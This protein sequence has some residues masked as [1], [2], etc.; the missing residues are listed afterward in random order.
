MVIHTTVSRLSR[1]QRDEL[2]ALRT[3]GDP[4]AWVAEADWVL[5]GFGAIPLALIAL[6]GWGQ[7]ELLGRWDVIR[8]YDYLLLYSVLFGYGAFF[9]LWFLNLLVRNRRSG[10][11]NA[12]F[13]LV[14]ITGGAATIFPHAD[15]QGV[16]L[17]QVTTGSM[18][19]DQTIGTSHVEIG[20]GIKVMHRHRQYSLAIIIERQL[21]REV[22]VFPN[23]DAATAFQT[24]LVGFM[25][26]S[27]PVVLPPS[28][29]EA[30]WLFPI[31][32]CCFMILVG[33]PLFTWKVFF[34]WQNREL[35]RRMDRDV[36][37]TGDSGKTGL[38]GEIRILQE[39]LRLCPEGQHQPA[40]ASR[41]AEISDDHIQ[42]TRRSLLADSSYRYEYQT[43][44]RE[45]LNKRSVASYARELAVLEEDDKRGDR[46]IP[47]WRALQAGAGS[48]T[49]A[50][51]AAKP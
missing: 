42:A 28:G 17:S 3:G 38:T 1:E 32:L 15:I 22:I 5:L 23:E 43:L 33:G 16:E 8:Y 37:I 2:R 6:V 30:G 35:E 21:E 20:G 39:Y 4:S 48:G 49:Q 13:G 25:G 14:R 27:E 51:A 44:L 29:A 34:P 31:A 41:E 18:L 24:R 11:V 50:E 19:N 47:G 36:F 7:F 26:N 9:V 40:V 46:E 12:S 10:Y 45:A